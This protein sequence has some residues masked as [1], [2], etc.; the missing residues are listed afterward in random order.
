[1]KLLVM[2]YMFIG[3]HIGLK[4]SCDEMLW[5]IVDFHLFGWRVLYIRNNSPTQLT[6]LIVHHLVTLDKHN[7]SNQKHDTT[8]ALTV[9]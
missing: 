4:F 8:A 2:P 9:K 6:N 7:E 1:M 5:F 3:I